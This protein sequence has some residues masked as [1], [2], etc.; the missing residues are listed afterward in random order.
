[1][2]L[3][4]YDVVACLLLLV[5]LPLG[6]PSGLADLRVTSAAACLLPALQLTFA[7]FSTRL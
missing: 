3:A 7:M 1:V 2:Y 4:Q 6:M 5:A